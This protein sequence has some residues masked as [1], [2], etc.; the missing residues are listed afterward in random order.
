MDLLRGANHQNSNVILGHY[1]LKLD[2]SA[3][4]KLPSGKTFVEIAELSVELV[5]RCIKKVH[6]PDKDSEPIVEYQDIYDWLKII[7]KK[8]YEQIRERVEQLSEN[9]IDT[10]FDANCAECGKDYKTNIELDIAGFFA[11]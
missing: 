3:D 8:D 11:G 2:S 7:T 5:A 10:T 9:N 6:L 1:W 4:N